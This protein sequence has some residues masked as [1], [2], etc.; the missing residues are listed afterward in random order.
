[1]WLKLNVITV[2]YNQSVQFSSVTQSCPTL[3]PHKP[4]HTRPPCPS[5]S[6]GVHP[7]SCPLSRWCHPIISS[8]AIPFSSS[9]NVSQHQGHFKWVSS[10]HQYLVLFTKLN[11]WL[12]Q[13]YLFSLYSFSSITT[14]ARLS[15]EYI[16]CEL[17]QDNL[18]Q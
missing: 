7:D 2:T 11:Y 12:F 5:P 1:M 13:V 18:L 14:V 6:P 17:D 10:S 8:S 3:W 15:K 4:Q 9:L 16:I